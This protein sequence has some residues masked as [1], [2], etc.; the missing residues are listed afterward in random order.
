MNELL[1]GESAVGMVQKVID[2]LVAPHYAV[3]LLLLQNEVTSCNAAC[4]IL[5]GKENLGDAPVHV[6]VR[7][8]ALQLTLVKSGKQQSTSVN[9]RC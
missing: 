1:P 3:I 7:H 5:D 4:Y 8:I 6:H 9:R 2:S